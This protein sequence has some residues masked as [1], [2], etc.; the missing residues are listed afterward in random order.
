MDIVL[1]IMNKSPYELRF[2]LNNNTHR[3]HL[4]KIK[5]A[6]KINGQYFSV[7]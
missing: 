6:I 5:R 4:A 3:T 1:Q 7:I 2:I